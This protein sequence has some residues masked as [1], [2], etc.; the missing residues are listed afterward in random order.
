MLLLR[1]LRLLRLSKRG[2]EYAKEKFKVGFFIALASLAW[3][4]KKNAI[5]IIFAD[6]GCKKIEGGVKGNGLVL[7]TTLLLH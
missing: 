2:L 6:V 1:L 5:R 4:M 7:P 3:R